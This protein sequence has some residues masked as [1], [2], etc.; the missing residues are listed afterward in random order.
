[1]N[2]ETI[3]EEDVYIRRITLEYE[4]RIANI[5]L[6]SFNNLPIPEEELTIIYNEFLQSLTSDQSKNLFYNQAKRLLKELHKKTINHQSTILKD[7][8]FKYLKSQFAIMEK[9]IKSNEIQQIAQLAQELDNQFP[10]FNEQL[11]NYSSNNESQIKLYLYQDYKLRLIQFA[12]AVFQ[13]KCEAMFIQIQSSKTKSDSLH[14]EEVN[15]LKEEF[16]ITSKRLNDNIDSLKKT[17]DSQSSK[18]K[19]IGDKVKQLTSDLINEKK[20]NEDKAYDLKQKHTQE[21]RRLQEKINAMEENSIINKTQIKKDSSNTEK[22][23]KILEM[24]ISNIKNQ[25]EEYKKR[26]ETLQSEHKTQIKEQID[27]LKSSSNQYESTIKDLKSRLDNALSKLIDLESSEK[28]N[29]QLIAFEKVNNEEL[30][31]KYEHDVA[32]LNQKLNEQKE[33]FNLEKRRLQNQIETKESSIQKMILTQRDAESETMFKMK[34]DE[35]KL[36]MKSK[37]IEQLYLSE[38][39]KNEFLLEKEKDLQEQLEQMKKNQQKILDSLNMEKASNG[40]FGI[41]NNS[42]EEKVENIQNIFLKEKSNI[43]NDHKKALEYY[44]GEIAKQKRDINSLENKMESIEK[45]LNESKAFTEVLTE[46]NKDLM[47]QNKMTES[48]RSNFNDELNKQINITNE[49]YERKLNEKE[50]YHQN[51][52]I[53]LNKNSETTLDQL[54]IIFTNEKARLEDRISESKKKNDKAISAIIAEYESKI[55]DNEHEYRSEI[56]ALQNSYDEL[57]ANFNQ[58]SIG[59]VHEITLLKQKVVT[60]ERIITENKETILNLTKEHNNAIQE[61]LNSFNVERKE[62][63]NKIEVLQYDINQKEQEIAQLNSDIK[64]MKDNLKE[65]ESSIQSQKKEYETALD[66]IIAKFEQY[67]NKQQEIANEFAIKKMDFERETRLLKQQIDY[68]NTKVEEHVVFVDEN[69]RIH[70]ENITELKTELEET[71]NCKVGEFLTEKKTLFERL[72]EA[73]VQIKSY[74][75]KL[76]AVSSFYEQKL[77]DEKNNHKLIYSQLES[78]LQNLSMQTEKLNKKSNDPIKKIN[79]LTEVQV[80]LQNENA[81]CKDSI[82]QLEKELDEREAALAKLQ[83]E[84]QEL[85]TENEILNSMIVQLKMQL[86]VSSPKN[87]EMNKRYKSNGTATPINSDQMKSNVD[88]PNNSLGFI[89]FNKKKAESASNSGLKRYEN[90]KIGK[91]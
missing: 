15:Q 75:D 48:I 38:K 53:A 86:K 26:E 70:D 77:K 82:I 52:I 13:S 47:K 49:H 14:K 67:K 56:E 72:K 37:Q 27:A 69:E 91:K 30:K 84:N 73:E 4:S 28:T 24:N 64:S 12:S 32:S 36:I 40:S 80:Q 54:K 22:E 6:S 78:E 7:Y 58:I 62:L 89:D 79:E 71:F 43:E 88:M 51:E 81:D 76:N 55:R 1:M 63:S 74:E 9:K 17:I 25:I 10:E 61:K 46:K 39:Q 21:I 31:N 66:A 29:E 60:A 23:K 45:E 83:N 85:I 5:S 35:E 90:K 34:T 59:G 41:S 20:Q 87:I 68:L 2:T 42:I 65:K 8:I 33:R 18:E 44:L 57:E 3:K 50:V 19:S 11:D 16:K